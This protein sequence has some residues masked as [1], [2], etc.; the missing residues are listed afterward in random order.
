MDYL[1]NYYSLKQKVNEKD[2]L[3][4]ID[5]GMNLYNFSFHSENKIVLTGEVDYYCPS[6]SITFSSIP[7]NRYDFSANEAILDS[8]D[9]W[10]FDT[11]FL[12][13]KIACP[14]GKLSFI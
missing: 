12:P 2:D 14:S 8:R 9:S 1:D 13:R 4:R 5:E 7:D 6:H 10:I 3:I 11:M